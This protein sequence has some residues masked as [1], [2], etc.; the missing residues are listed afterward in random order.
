MPSELLDRVMDLLTEDPA[1]TVMNAVANWNGAGAGP[2][3]DVIQDVRTVVPHQTAGWPAR[4]KSQEFVRR[5]T[6]R[7]I[8]ANANNEVIP[9]P[10][11]PPTN[12]G[13][14]AAGCHCLW[15][16]GPMYYVSYDGTIA[17]LVSS[18]RTDARVTF[19]AGWVNSTSVGVE[20]GN[21]FRTAAP[22]GSGWVRV[23]QNPAGDDLTG[24]NLYLRDM[25][26][27]PR[28]VIACWWTTANYAG[29]ARGNVGAG[30]MLFSEAQYRSWALLGRFFA[31]Q[32]EV[33]RN[34]PLLP[35]A[36]RAA[37]VTDGDSYRRIVLA[38]PAFDVITAR[39]QPAWQMNAGMFAA[40]PAGL[41]A[42]YAAL[43]P[44][45]TVANPAWTSL[46]T[47]FR[48]FH[49]HD[50]SGDNHG[51]D[52][53]CPGP[54]FDWHR[55][56]RELWDWWWY[57]FDVADVPPTTNM[58]TATTRRGYQRPDASTPLIEHYFDDDNQ[59][60]V[61]G[62]PLDVRHGARSRDGIQGVTSAP[63]TWRLDQGSPVYAMANGE[64]VAARFAQPS[65][66]VSMSF[67]LVRH[68]IFQRTVGGADLVQS[69]RLDYDQAA[70]TVYSLYMHIGHPADLDLTAVN[71]AN[72]DWLNRVHV[73]WKESDLGLRFYNDPTHHGIPTAAWN[74][75]LPGQAARPALVD[76]WRID[77]AALTTFR[78]DLAAGR[79]AMAPF[80]NQTTPIQII[81][82]DYLGNDGVI[83][84]E[85]G[86]QIRGIRV[87]VFSP[88]VLPGFTLTGAGASWTGLP[89]GFTGTPVQQFPSEWAR[90]LSDAD[91]T[92]LTALGVDVTLVT[93]WPATAQ[94][95]ALD[96][97]IIA[98]DRLPVD[99]QVFHYQP[100]DFLRW[101]NKIT[102]NSEWPKYQVLDAAGHAQAA[103]AQPRSR[104]V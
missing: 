1:T 66:V 15:G 33:P 76:S 62:T 102:W 97:R 80:A 43:A 61:L 83:A 40:D 19:H 69:L 3:G 20:T 103:P 16:I 74:Q 10:N 14:G 30:L 90:D 5:Y 25:H 24:A 63:A 13:V 54:L 57:P 49:G 47:A 52:H 60:D 23:A 86:T 68:R 50:V 91:K 31:E 89:P 98:A 41:N 9:C 88:Q 101:I 29:P 8:G 92:G 45:G 21:L 39:L 7:R 51:Q 70:S 65:G 95:M 11:C 42:A 77:Q 85:N 75:P 99:G 82:G 56:A 84:N 34:V 96:P 2:W 73:R 12:Q 87:E 93:W 28:E 44:H 48:G 81:L 4:S 22:P 78:T 79:V 59:N 35:W 55:F 58:T 17:R 64:L 37:S 6:V 18:V 32:F 94:A 46:F 36:S 38:D 26:E 104:R 72:P 53:D 27:N 67:V 71:T 100:F